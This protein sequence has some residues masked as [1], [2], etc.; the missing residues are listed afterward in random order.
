MDKP[1]FPRNNLARRVPLLNKQ[2]I[3][4]DKSAEGLMK[5]RS[6]LLWKK[7]AFFAVIL[8]FPVAFGYP[9]STKPQ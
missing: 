9:Q 8:V 5:L 6:A 1:A 2:S 7:S 3:A 4:S